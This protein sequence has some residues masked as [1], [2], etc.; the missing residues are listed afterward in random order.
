[1]FRRLQ[2]G[3]LF[4]LW[5]NRLLTGRRGERLRGGPGIAVAKSLSVGN[6]SPN[7]RMRGL[8]RARNFALE[9]HQDGIF[10]VH[11]WIT[12]R[13]AKIRRLDYTPTTFSILA[14]W[15]PRVGQQSGP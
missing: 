6:P 5:A 10:G 13:A 2:L 7:H 9:V 11:F 8:P 4:S 12:L 15:I 3:K 14:A 1:M